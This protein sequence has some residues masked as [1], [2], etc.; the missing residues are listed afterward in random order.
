MQV[1]IYESAGLPYPFVDLRDIEKVNMKVLS[2]S[3]RVGDMEDSV[4]NPDEGL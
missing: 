4:A 3:C 2:K 1:T